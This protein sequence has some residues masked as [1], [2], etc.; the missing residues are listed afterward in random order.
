MTTIASK[1]RQ[2]ASIR[3]QWQPM[4]LHAHSLL[5]RRIYAVLYANSSFASNRTS[6]SSWVRHDDSFLKIDEDYKI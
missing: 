6:T 5:L 3:S 4:A 2:S 1:V